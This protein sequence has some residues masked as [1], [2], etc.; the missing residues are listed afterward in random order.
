MA[1]E[2][3]TTQQVRLEHLNKLIAEHLID[4]DSF[5]ED[6][7]EDLRPYLGC[8]KEISRWCAL[9]E[10]GD[11][12]FAYPCYRTLKEACERA[13]EYA[14]DSIYSEYPLAVVDLDR[15]ATYYP[16]WSTLKFIKA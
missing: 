5:A 13:V 15:Y 14:H 4:W 3:K 1:K 2:V 12:T 8:E 9:A 11:R 10:H 7:E 6:V 16:A